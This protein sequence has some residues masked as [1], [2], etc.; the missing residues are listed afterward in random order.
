MSPRKSV[1][2]ELTREMI[3]DAARDLF[4]S[5]GYQHVSMRQIAK[6]L[7]YSH[8]SIY[9]HF[10]NKA[11]LFYALVEKH[12]EL[13]DQ[14]L[15]D[16]L[17]Q[18]LDQKEK[19]KQILVGYIQFGLNHQSHYEIM[20]LIKDEEVRN[21]INQG[22]NRSYE[23]FAQSVSLLSGKELKVQEIWLLFLSLHGFVTHYCRI[24]NS[25]EEVRGLA[26]AHADFLLKSI[27]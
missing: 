16:V 2:K 23:N 24:V 21:F 25:Y 18:K 10:K 3:M 15:H 20:F 6:E 9:Y 14:K 17:K 4:V 8:G 12:F 27:H 7:G 13:L 11:E 19:L 5:K 26:E 1:Q 22:G